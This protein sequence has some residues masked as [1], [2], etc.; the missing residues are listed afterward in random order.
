MLDVKI[1]A[2]CVN[3]AIAYEQINLG[4]PSGCKKAVDPMMKC[5]KARPTPLMEMNQAFISCIQVLSLQCL[6]C[7]FVHKGHC[8]IYTSFSI[9]VVEP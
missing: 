4:K 3:K 9:A 7:F 2:T 1:N 6:T 5:L 8:A